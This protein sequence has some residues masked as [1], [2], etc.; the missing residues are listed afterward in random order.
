MNCTVIGDHINWKIDGEPLVGDEHAKFSYSYQ[1][2]NL[3]NEAANKRIG[4]LRIVGL[5]TTSNGTMVTCVV[6]QLRNTLFSVAVSKPALILVQ[7]I[8]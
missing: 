4:Q 8:L 7:G 5:N 6:S 3:L 1:S 2:I